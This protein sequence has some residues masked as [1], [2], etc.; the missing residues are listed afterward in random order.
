MNFCELFFLLNQLIIFSAPR[1][2]YEHD[3]RFNP[4]QCPRVV[5]LYTVDRVR[6]QGMRLDSNKQKGKG[7]EG[8]ETF[9]NPM[10]MSVSVYTFRFR[11]NI[12]WTLVLCEY[13]SRTFF[14]VLD[15]QRHTFTVWIEL[16]ALLQFRKYVLTE[17]LGIHNM[18]FI[19]MHPF[20]NFF[21]GQC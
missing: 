17:N 12:I 2:V 19:Y 4:W 6:H 10:L 14:C 15:I 5:Q 13:L 1:W 18:S 21:Q 11:I 3:A 16:M 9:S 7:R 8:I 20:H